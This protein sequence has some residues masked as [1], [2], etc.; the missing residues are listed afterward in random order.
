MPQVKEPL[1]VHQDGH[2]IRDNSCTS[3]VPCIPLKV[4][5]LSNISV[6]WQ[7]GHEEDPNAPNANGNLGLNRESG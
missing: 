6:S 7:P 1:S 2:S 3:L 5:A 4:P